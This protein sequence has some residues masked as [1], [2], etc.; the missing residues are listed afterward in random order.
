MPDSDQFAMLLREAAVPSDGRFAQFQATRLI[1]RGGMGIVVAAIDHRL[2]REVAIKLMRPERARSE[3]ARQMF[4]TEA[5]AMAAL[6]HDNIIP[7]YE[8]GEV[9]QV[10]FLAM[11][12]LKGETIDSLLNRGFAFSDQQIAKL[13]FQVAAGLH[14]AHREGIIHRD[15]KPGNIFLELPRGRVKVLDF[16][17]ARSAKVSEVADSLLVGTPGYL[18]PEQA[19]DDKIDVRS[20]LFS[21]GVVLYRMATGKLP[22]QAG[23]LAEMLVKLLTESPTPLQQIRPDLPGELTDIVDRC[24]KS[25]PSER[26]ATAAEVGRALKQT[27]R[28]LSASNNSDIQIVVP[29]TSIVETMKER[30]RPPIGRRSG[31]HFMLHA[32][33]AGSAMLLLVGGS[34]WI[35]TRD[36]SGAEDGGG[37]QESGVAVKSDSMVTKETAT[38]TTSINPAVPVEQSE[39]SIPTRPA[40]NIPDG[41]REF[42]IFDSSG[43]LS[44]DCYVTQDSERDVGREPYL[45]VAG[46]RGQPQQKAYLRFDISELREDRAV[47]A[48]YLLL[49]LVTTG[50]EEP[51]DLRFR[52]GTL[53]D[54]AAANQTWRECGKDRII[55][56]DQPVKVPSVD[57]KE[58]GIM[59]ALQSAWYNH[60]EDTWL[61]MQHKTSGT[62]G[63]VRDD[64]DGFLTFVIA[65]EKTSCPP[66][67]FV[68]R[69]GSGKY[70][71]KLIIVYE[72]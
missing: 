7:V 19:R 3:Q 42:D 39:R 28:A 48:A 47:K 27:H 21:L 5:R 9:R 34:Y 43:P 50:D 64:T 41:L 17:L 45:R 23:D 70:G 14:A 49:T 61:L 22:W 52:V 25:R 33:L 54:N 2:Q 38:A 72:N 10:P 6:R 71:P 4:L 37:S 36:M 59:N 60:P 68:S 12:L 67:R 57:L 26:P 18:S 53:R 32:A 35:G 40:D 56:A 65:P 58:T 69:D 29:E 30:K 62:T 24:L 11:E 15:I 13:G 55:F 63:A 16:G 1:G 46:A 66:V 51:D 31:N 20:D 44:A 8:V